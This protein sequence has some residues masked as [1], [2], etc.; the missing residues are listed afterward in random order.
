MKLNLQKISALI[1]MVAVVALLASAGYK[2]YRVKRDTYQ[3][4][5][6]PQAVLE[7]IK[8]KHVPYNTIKPPAITPTDAFIFGSPTST[9]GVIFFGDYANPKSNKLFKELEPKLR[10][11]RGIRLVWRDLPSSTEDRNPSFEAAVLSE[12]SRFLDPFWKMRYLLG[13]FTSTAL[14][15]WSIDSILSQLSNSEM[16][17]L[18][19]CRRDQSVR[20][21]LRQA[22]AISKGDGIDTAPFLFVVSQAISAQDASGTRVFDALRPYIK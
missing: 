7:E 16:Q 15:N 18:E 17:G 21:T 8:P 14:D 2:F 11:Y 4:G 10:A 22:I 9:A 12:C 6:P 19:T 1:L 5:L 20:N 3:A 13:S